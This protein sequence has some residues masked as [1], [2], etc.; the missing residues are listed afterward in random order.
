MPDRTWNC[1]GDIID[2]IA[3]FSLPAVIKAACPAGY[4]AKESEISDVFIT[5]Y[6]DGD[7][8]LVDGGTV[9]LPGAAW[10]IEGDAAWFDSR[11]FVLDNATAW[12]GTQVR[13]LLCVGDKPLPEF[14]Q[15][16]VARGWTKNVGTIHTINLDVTDH[17]CSDPVAPDPVFKNYDFTRVLQGQP[18]VVVWFR[19]IGGI[20]V[21]GDLG[22]KCRVIQAG[23]VF[24]RGE[25][26]LLTSQ[27]ILE[28]DAACDPPAAC[29]LNTDPDLIAIP[30]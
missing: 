9:S 16:T 22:I 7:Y 25:G 15:I 1:D 30:A 19:T 24:G 6:G 13:S 8:A 14:S 18:T 26:T 17:P 4:G 29:D 2:C 28:F 27:I 11:T 23:N 5:L 3:G 10:T 20:I 12:S 21:G